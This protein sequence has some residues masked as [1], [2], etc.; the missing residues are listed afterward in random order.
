MQNEKLDKLLLESAGCTIFLHVQ[1]I[2]L[3]IYNLQQLLEW[4]L[5]MV[6][7]LSS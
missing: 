2:P 1:V 6:Q 4:Q 7:E 3:Y 5:I